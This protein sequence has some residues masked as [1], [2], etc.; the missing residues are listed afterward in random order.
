MLPVTS[1][2][3]PSDLGSGSTTDDRGGGNAAAAIN[4]ME[5]VRRV[6]NGRSLPE[7]GYLFK[8]KVD[9]KD[10]IDPIDLGLM[11]LQ[12]RRKG[13]LAKFYSPAKYTEQVKTMRTAM[14]GKQDG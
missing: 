13:G 4:R 8:E 3:D 14:E 10:V 11:V 1:E 9:I 7:A 5:Q 12:A 6:G 2:R